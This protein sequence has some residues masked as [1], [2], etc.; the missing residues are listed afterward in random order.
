MVT[1]RSVTFSTYCSCSII[2]VIS[3]STLMFRS[4]HSF[5]VLSANAKLYF[6]ILINASGRLRMWTY[7]IKLY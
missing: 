5:V 7:K 6:S 4:D 3:C 1:D 2:L